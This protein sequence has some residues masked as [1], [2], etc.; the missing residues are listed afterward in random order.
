[1]QIS[2]SAISFACVAGFAPSFQKYGLQPNLYGMLGGNTTLLCQPEAAPEPDKEW[3]KD[4][5]PLNTGTNPQD[6]VLLLSNGNIHI[7]GLT[8]GDQGE[9]ECRAT[10]QYGTDLTRGKLTVLR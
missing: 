2:N 4:G 6:R 8:Q 10:N 1:V 3:F 5:A 7:T 9:Y